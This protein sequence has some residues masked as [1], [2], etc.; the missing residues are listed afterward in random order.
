[1]YPPEMVNAGEIVL[2]RWDSQWAEELATA[3]RASLKELTPFMPWAHLTYDDESARTFLRSA[4]EEWDKGISFGYG[5]FTTVGELVGA[6]GLMTR[7]G[8]GALEIGYWI[9]SAYAGRGYATRAASALA[10]VGLSMPGVERIVIKHDAANPASGAVAAKA[11]FT[12]VG[13][14]E[15]TPEAPGESGIDVTWERR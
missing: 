4:D 5:V 6:C 9:H 13:R 11:G 14:G 15:R 10:Q 8:P 7:I 12:E 3:V 2:K 1:M